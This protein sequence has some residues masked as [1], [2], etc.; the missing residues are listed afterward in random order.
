MF[1]SFGALLAF[2]L[3]A[4]EHP[5]TSSTNT[6]KLVKS[7]VE[8]FAAVSSLDLKNVHLWEAVM[9]NHYIC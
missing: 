9:Q 1:L 7:P 3:Q 4:E 8:Y 2:H 5:S 6:F